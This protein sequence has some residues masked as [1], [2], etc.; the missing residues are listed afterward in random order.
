MLPSG[1]PWPKVSIVTP[2]FN[3]GR[4]LEATIRSVLLQGYPNL[5]YVVIDAGSMDDSVNIIRRYERWLTY[6]E[7]VPDGGQSHAINKG[8]LNC[9]GEIFNWINSDDRLAPGALG[10]L[11]S[12]WTQEQPHVLIGRCL[13]IE[14]ENGAILHDLQPKPPKR[15]L[16]FLTPYRVVMPQPSTFLSLST[17]R[18]LG[19]ANED[20]HCLMDWE[21]YLKLVNRLRDGMRVATTTAVLSCFQNHPASKSNQ[22]GPVF[23]REAEQVLDALRPQLPLI[24]RLQLDRYIRRV[25]AEELLTK[26]LAVPGQLLVRLARLS[27]QR[28]Y[29]LRSRSFWGAV[30]GAA[31]KAAKGLG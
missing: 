31:T 22:Q 16:D 13:A 26:T 9:T 10:E 19:R 7:S 11:G 30:Y 28:P 6:W 17:F 3:Y 15:P 5:D 4:F 24:E 18:E 1:Q 12:I 21:L 2:N 29:L 8:S 25:R 20:L 23:R 27:F 14:G